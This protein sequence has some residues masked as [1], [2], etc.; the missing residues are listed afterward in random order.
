MLTKIPTLKFAG[1]KNKVR[2][3]ERPGN[4]P[5][6]PQGDEKLGDAGDAKMLSS[7][8]TDVAKPPVAVRRIIE[9]GNEAHFGAE[10]FIRNARFR[11]G[12]EGRFPRD[13]ELF[14]GRA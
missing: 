11:Q 9:K 3:S 13:R 7:Q 1:R 12:K 6:Q 14:S 8:V 10:N 4:G 5:L 2:G